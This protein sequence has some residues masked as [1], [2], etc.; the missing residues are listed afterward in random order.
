MERA[1]CIG[2]GG[3]EADRALFRAQGRNVA[4]IM[5]GES[6]TKGIR[7]EAGLCL[8]VVGRQCAEGVQQV[9]NNTVRYID[10]TTLIVQA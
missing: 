1:V 10:A 3:D 2:R 8:A 6:W 7:E 5:P 4:E 9:H